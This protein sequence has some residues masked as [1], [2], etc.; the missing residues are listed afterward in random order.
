MPQN[1]GKGG[2]VSGDFQTKCHDAMMLWLFG[3]FIDLWQTP[4]Q[5]SAIY[6]IITSTSSQFEL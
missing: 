6:I 5:L 4:T 1:W 3:Y 2:T